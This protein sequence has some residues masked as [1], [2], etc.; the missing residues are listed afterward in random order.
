MTKPHFTRLFFSVSQNVRLT[1]WA[2]HWN[3]NVFASISSR[4]GII[5][6]GRSTESLSS[7]STE[8]PDPDISKSFRLTV[9]PVRGCLN[10]MSG[11]GATCSLVLGNSLDLNRDIRSFKGSSTKVLV[12]RPEVWLSILQFPE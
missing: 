8:K 12:F 5:I 6:P 9:F 11:E 7:S 1:T 4:L 3:F 10:T 2:S